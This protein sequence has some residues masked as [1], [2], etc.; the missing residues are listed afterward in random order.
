[1]TAKLRAIKFSAM[2][3]HVAA[4]LLHLKGCRILAHE[5]R[6]PLGEIDIIARH[7]WT[8]AFIEVKARATRDQAIE[9]VSSHQ[10]GRI[11]R[12][13]LAYTTDHLKFAGFDLCFDLIAIASWQVPRHLPNAWQI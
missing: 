7:G 4:G 11:E 3:E 9:A 10:R 13:A 6:L 5:L 8:L 1:M 12:A 2:A